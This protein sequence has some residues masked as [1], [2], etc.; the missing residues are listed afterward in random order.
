M[1]IVAIVQARMN[2]SRLP[3][4]V[5]AEIEGRPM[6][7]YLI[8]RISKASSINEIIV[9]TTDSPSDDV[10]SDWVKEYAKLNCYRG[11][12]CD[13]LDRF[14]QSA[15]KYEA[16][17]IVRVTADDP[18]KD[19]EI[20]EK[21]ISY[22]KKIPNLDYCSNTIIPSY[23]EGLD[24]EVFRFSALEQAWLNATLL[25]EREHVTPY[26]WKN[27]E[28]FNLYNFLNDRDLSAWRWT[29]DKKN[30]LDFVKLIFKKFKNNYDVN[31]KEIVEY[32]DA[33]PKVASINDGTIR[34]EGYIRSVKKEEL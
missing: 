4:K 2:S 26:I 18:L 29:V 34:N 9:A 13:V 10:I 3:G 8:G 32:I 17:L 22:F 27:G 5:L 14:Y 31:F 15:K 1:K 6:L 21:A 25:S 19:P 7:E 11:S 16:D 24:I 30:D 28:I 23:P 12:E 33:N 20:I